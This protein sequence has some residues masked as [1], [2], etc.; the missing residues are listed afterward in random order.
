MD[1]ELL[2]VSL[3]GA[4]IGHLGNLTEMAP[5]IANVTELDLGGNCISD[6]MQVSQCCELLDFMEN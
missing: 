5:L 3:N 2:L 4:S 6:W 1:G